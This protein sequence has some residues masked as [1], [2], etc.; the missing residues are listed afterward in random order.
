MQ[1]VDVVLGELVPADQYAPEAVRPTMRAFHHPT[2]GFETSLP[3]D[4]LGLFAPTADV[5]GETEL[6]QVRR[7]SG[8]S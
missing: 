6:L 5:G 3:F 2:P 8:K 4:G 7:T 1:K